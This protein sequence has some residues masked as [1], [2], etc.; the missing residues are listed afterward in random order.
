[1]KELQQHKRDERCLD[2]GLLISLRDGELNA[3]QQAHAQAHLATC[4]DCA[5]S[6]QVE[7]QQGQEVYAAL[8]SLQP[9]AHEIPETAK[10]FAFFQAK[11]ALE[12]EQR[13]LLPF[14]GVEQR[15]GSSGVLRKAMTRRSWLVA[16]VAAVLIALLVLP[17][18]SVLASQLLGLFQ[19]QQFQSVSLDARQAQRDVFADL[20]HF[21]SVSMTGNNGRSVSENQTREQV[22]QALHFPLRLPTHLPADVNNTPHFQIFHGGQATFVFD[23]AKAKAYMQQIGDGGVAIPRELVGQTYDVTLAPGVSVVYSA[24]CQQSAADKCKPS[25]RV[26]LEEIPAPQVQGSERDALKDL[27][28]FMLSLPHLSASTR[29]LWQHVDL[30]KGIVPLPLISPQTNAQQVRIQGASGLL[31]SD[32]AVHF[33]GVIWQAQGIVYGLVMP[34]SDKTQI[35]TIANSLR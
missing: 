10:A 8:S 29:T 7:R 24:P 22:Q 18:A 17:N 3:E 2:R 9:D 19:V 30:D 5:T 1:M 13:R 25:P 12:S 33:G 16:A 11:L 6:Q 35:L 15:Q 32:P 26:M 31:L 14:P 4:V 28:S 34:T 21:G 23:A 20:S 27:R